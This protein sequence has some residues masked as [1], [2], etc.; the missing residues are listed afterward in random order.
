MFQKWS[1]LSFL[2]FAVEPQEIQRTLPPSLTVDTFPD[3]T[4]KEMAWVGFVPF[5]IDQLSFNPKFVIPFPQSF[6]E[7]NVR[8][9]VHRNRKDPGVWFYSLD[10][11][12]KLACNAARLWFGLP[13]WPARMTLEFHGNELVYE[14]KRLD[15]D[16]PE[17]R[18]HVRIGDKLDDP[19]PGEFLF[20]LI[21][22]YLLYSFYRGKIHT[23]RVFHA[24]YSLY[25][26]GLESVDESLV[27]A[28]GLNRGPFTSLL[29]SP[30]VDVTVFPLKPI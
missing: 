29:F 16:G 3:E 9:Y 23:G 21:E 25:E 22:R 27:K 4:G 18:V 11:A 20:F 8:T 26:M 19:Q 1:N 28:A 12:S 6:L 10:A 2:H 17:Y 13:Y 14:G 15:L 24:P 30:G 5:E 7:T